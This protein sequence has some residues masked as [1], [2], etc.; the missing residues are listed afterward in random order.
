MSYTIVAFIWRKPGTSPSEF[1]T[2][3]EK[4]HIPLL[5]DLLAAVFPLS[6]SRFYLKRTPEDSSLSDSSN[7]N[8]RPTVLAGT[9]DDFAYDVY[10]ELVFEDE[11]SF[12]AFHAGMREPEVAA[13]I[14]EDEEKFMDRQLMKVAAVAEP[15]ITSRPSQ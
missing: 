6:H 14:A 11:S 12:H 3:Y 13:K 8:Y 4:T 1:K 15:V 9:P 10:C 7:S 5:L 2:H